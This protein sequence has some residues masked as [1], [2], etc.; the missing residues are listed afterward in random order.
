MK[1]KFYRYKICVFGDGGVGKTTLVNRYLTGVFDESLVMTLGMEFFVKKLSVA[2]INCS[3]QIWDFAG[4]REF[5]ALLPSNVRNASGGI[6]V[7]DISRYS[8]IKNLN[9]WITIFMENNKGRGV[10]PILLVGSKL[11][12]EKKRAIS[13]KE[14]RK[15]A[16][17]HGFFEY[18]ECSSKTGENIE[19]I[20]TTLSHEIVKQ[21]LIKAKVSADFK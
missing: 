3:L 21:G 7:F 20:F 19:K 4:E 6:F 16:K 12:L 5:R 11:D 9:D 18:I 15:M 14:G 1:S 10:I 13:K 17:K 8:S 2:A